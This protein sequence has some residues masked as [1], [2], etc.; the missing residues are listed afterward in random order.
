MLII[1]IELPVGSFLIQIAI[2]GFVF[3]DKARVDEHKLREKLGC[4]IYLKTNKMPQ[5]T[6]FSFQ[7]PHQHTQYKQKRENE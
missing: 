6:V 7:V 5:N 1:S 2:N 3:G 4:S